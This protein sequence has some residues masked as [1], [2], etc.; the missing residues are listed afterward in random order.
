[1]H[2][3]QALRS[4]RR[5]H[6]PMQEAPLQRRGTKREAVVIGALT[7]ERIVGGRYEWRDAEYVA[8]KGPRKRFWDKW[9][10]ARLYFKPAPPLRL[11]HVSMV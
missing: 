5:G 2:I 8:I 6:M 3:K 7:V 4:T 11:P 10:A 1:M 9:H